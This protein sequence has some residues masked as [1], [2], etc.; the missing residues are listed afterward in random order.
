MTIAAQRRGITLTSR[1]RPLKPEDFHRFEYI[2]CMDEKN[3]DDVQIAAD[4]WSAKHPIPAD[5]RSRVK[6]MTT[7]CKKFKRDAVPDPYFGGSKGFEI[8]LDLLQDSCEGLL[9]YIE[10]ER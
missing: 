8:V 1:S 10:R 2:I 3:A 7:F 9:S 6:M 5:L 4:Y